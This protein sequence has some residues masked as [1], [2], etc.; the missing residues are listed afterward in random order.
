[1]WHQKLNTHKVKLF[2]NS[3]REAPA[4]FL[5]SA[6]FAMFNQAVGVN[7]SAATFRL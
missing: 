5:P 1:M 4:G 2:S 6:D 7:T 3:V